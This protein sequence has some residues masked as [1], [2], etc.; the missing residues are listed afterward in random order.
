LDL[1]RRRG[2]FCSTRSSTV[3]R[4]RRRAGTRHAIQTASG[5][6]RG[7]G[8]AQLEPDRAGEALRRG[9]GHSRQ[10]DGC[11]SRSTRRR[12]SSPRVPP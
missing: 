12:R 10:G 4:C 6:A 5:Y 8:A 7:A 1:E 3:S 9:A 11:G 2:L